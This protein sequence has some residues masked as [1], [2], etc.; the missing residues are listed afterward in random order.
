MGLANETGYPHEGY[1]DF[2]QP[3]VEPISGTLLIRGVFAN[4][5]PYVLRAGLFVRVR[6]PV[7]TQSAALLVPD[8]AIGTDQ[9][10]NYLLMIG[11]DDVVQRRSVIPARGKAMRVITQGVQARRAIHCPGTANGAAGSESESQDAELVTFP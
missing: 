11:P 10:G 8:S 7:G 1:I 9:A 3:T 4:P 6:V 5:E 2:A